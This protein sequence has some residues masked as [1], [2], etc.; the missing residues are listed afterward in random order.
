MSTLSSLDVSDFASFFNAIHGHDPFPWQQRLATTVATTDWP[1]L[2]DLPTGTGKT[3]ALDIAVFALALSA[4]KVNRASPRRVVYVVDRRT[5]VSQA[6]DRSQRIR[7][8]ITNA[9]DGVLLRVRERLSTLSGSGVPLRTVELR[10]GIA[11]DDAWART[12]D[13]P[14]IVV[15]TVDQ[16]GSRLLFRGYGI[17]DGMKPVHAGL[18]GND[19]LYLLDEVHLSQPFR[20]TLT[21]VATRYRT[22]AE[23][24]IASPFVVVEMSAT[25]AA[26]SRNPFA[27]NEADYQHPV[28]ARRLQALKPVTLVAAKPRK[29]VEELARQAKTLLDRPGATVGVVVNRIRTARELFGLLEDTDGV[30]AHLITG[31][32]RPY[33][34]DS[35]DRTL[36]HSRWPGSEPG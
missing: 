10:G 30:D 26:E 24:P 14:L 35:L 15:S 21:A 27:L 17:T 29:L 6:H 1:A 5:I 23:T 12:P 9:K 36:L 4:D 34:R 22:W 33:D 11:R 25:P 16:V 32:M 13:Q 3:A 31:R 18:L 28:L 8:A 19:V 7:A 2:L 20:E